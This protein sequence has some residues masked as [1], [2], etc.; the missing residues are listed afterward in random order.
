MTTPAPTPAALTPHESRIVRTTRLLAMAHAAEEVL[1]ELCDL[2]RFY[3]LTLAAYRA[4][5]ALRKRGVDVAP[6]RSEMRGLATVRERC[7]S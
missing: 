1:V 3:A 7:E 2:D 5:D 6:I 4:E